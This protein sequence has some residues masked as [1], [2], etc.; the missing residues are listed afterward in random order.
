MELSTK[1]SGTSKEE[2]MDVESK[3]GLMGHYMRVTGKMTKQTV[4]V[5]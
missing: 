5:V 2:R 4:E 3:F 1:A